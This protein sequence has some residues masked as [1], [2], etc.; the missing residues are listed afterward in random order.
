VKTFKKRH[1]T[2]INLLMIA[3]VVFVLVRTW[4]LHTPETFS[5]GS[6]IGEVAYDACLAY[7]TAWLFQ[8]LVIARPE[9]HRR[10]RLHDLIAPRIDHIIELGIELG[11]VIRAQRG[12]TPTFPVDSS[13]VLS[14]LTVTDPRE[15][16]PGWMADWHRVVADLSE[17]AAIQRA[18]LKPF[19]AQLDPKVLALLELEEA[20]M[21]LLTRVGRVS[22]EV[23]WDQMKNL[24]TPVTDWLESV[25]ALRQH[26]ISHLAPKRPVPVPNPK[27]ADF[28]RVPIGQLEAMRREIEELADI[29]ANGTEGSGGDA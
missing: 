24:V 7:A 12:E 22:A 26:R 28:Q 18:A 17:T 1:V 19:Y 3:A 8:W 29:L 2:S 6:E 20:R 5:Y 13:E 25:E 16:A 14:T 11:T 4:L 27:R 21:A 23:E 15:D 10:E 9:K